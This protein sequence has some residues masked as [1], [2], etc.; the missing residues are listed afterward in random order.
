MV[1]ISLGE[2]AVTKGCTGGEQWR[3]PMT[4]VY[5]IG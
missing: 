3:T 1:A 5:D 2:M 4:T